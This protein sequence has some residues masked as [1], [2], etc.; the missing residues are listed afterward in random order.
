LIRYMNTLPSEVLCW[1]AGWL[2]RADQLRLRAVNRTFRAVVDSILTKL[3]I[4]LLIT[5]QTNVSELEFLQTTTLPTRMLFCKVQAWPGFRFDWLHSLISI[6]PTVNTLFLSDVDTFAV[7]AARRTAAAITF[8]TVTRLRLEDCCIDPKTI[9]T[10]L[11]RLFPNVRKL[12]VRAIGGSRID[13]YLRVEIRAYAWNIDE[14]DIRD[15]CGCACSETVTSIVFQLL[16]QNPRIKLLSCDTFFGRIQKS[17]CQ[18]WCTVFSDREQ[19]FPD[20]FVII[21]CN[22]LSRYGEELREFHSY[23]IQGTRVWVVGRR[24]NFWKPQWW[25]V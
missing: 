7:L 11:I 5:Q 14:L 23:H 21:Q 20:A 3:A 1:L 2:K 19:T 4:R 13:R 8:P 16:A 17:W 24:V 25:L 12:C 22:E 9:T 10:S 15:T 6:L 18:H